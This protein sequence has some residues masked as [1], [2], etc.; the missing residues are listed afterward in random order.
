V[1]ADSGRPI[2]VL[3]C[4]QGFVG[5]K[6]SSSARLECNKTNYET[7]HVER[8]EHGQVF[9]KGQNGRYWTPDDGISATGEVPHPFYMELREPTRMCI[10]DVHGHYLGAQKNGSFALDSTDVAQATYWEF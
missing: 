10:K 4:E 1:A 3:R 5:Y 9:F 6:S 8:G 7:V 2:L